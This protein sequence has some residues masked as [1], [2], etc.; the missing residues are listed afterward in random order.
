MSQAKPSIAKRLWTGIKN[1]I[2]AYQN[3]YQRN[4]NQGLGLGKITNAEVPKALAEIAKKNPAKARHLEFNLLLWRNTP[5]IFSGLSQVAGFGNIAQAASISE[6]T[7]LRS[8][9]SWV[10]ESSTEVGSGVF[11]SVDGMKQFRMTNSDL[12]GSHGQIGPHV[13]FESLNSAG[14]VV[15]NMHVPIIP[16]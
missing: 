4:E 3:Y 2:K 6:G 1:G 8:G 10:G 15:E 13:H 11:R 7:A 16:D 5:L 14:K 12:L 9:S